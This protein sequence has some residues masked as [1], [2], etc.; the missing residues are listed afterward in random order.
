MARAEGGRAGRP[1]RP[2]KVNILGIEYQI[3]YVDNPAEVDPQKRE[4]LWGHVDYWEHIIR[5]YDKATGDQEVWQTIFH[6]MLHVICDHLKIKTL[7]HDH[8]DLL[9]MAL[10]DV[11][12]RNDWMRRDI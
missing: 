3:R 10:T 8:V 11:L 5:I 1:M 9:A 6:E 7:K 12:F 4:S 2:E